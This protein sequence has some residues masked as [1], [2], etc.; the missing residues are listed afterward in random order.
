MFLNR[1]NAKNYIWSK[2]LNLKSTERT[3]IFLLF[4]DGNNDESLKSNSLCY[5]CFIVI[6][7]LM[8][9]VIL[10]HGIELLLTQD[11]REGMTE[12]LSQWW[13]DDAVVPG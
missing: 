13:L 9:E 8:R 2:E 1:K 4:K 3:H 10:A 5:F 7:Q 11:R 12:W 6:T